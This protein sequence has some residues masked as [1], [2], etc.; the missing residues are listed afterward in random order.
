MRTLQSSESIKVTP[1][2]AHL[3]IIDVL[4]SDGYQKFFCK[5]CH[6]LHT[7]ELKNA[8][9]NIIDD[10][11]AE[12]QRLSIIKEESKVSWCGPPLVFCSYN[13]KYNPI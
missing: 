8:W 13:Y 4:W 7:T 6:L 3:F 1:A 2:F 12:N 11:F 10:L 5:S 9:G